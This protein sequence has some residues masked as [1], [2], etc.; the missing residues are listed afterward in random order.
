MGTDLARNGFIRMQSKFTKSK[1]FYL[2]LYLFI[3]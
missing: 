3:R 1:V 2:R